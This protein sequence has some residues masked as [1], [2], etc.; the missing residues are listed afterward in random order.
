MTLDVI[1]PGIHVFEHVL[2]YLL[3]RAGVSAERQLAMSG[4]DMVRAVATLEPQTLLSSFLPSA[5]P[6]SASQHTVDAAF[7]LSSWFQ[8]VYH[9]TVDAEDQLIRFR[10][11]REGMMALPTPT[12]TAFASLLEKV[13]LRDTLVK[14]SLNGSRF[15]LRHH[16]RFCLLIYFFLFW[17]CQTQAAPTLLDTF[18]TFLKVDRTEY[19]RMLMDPALADAE[20]YAK[21]CDILL[22]ALVGLVVVQCGRWTKARYSH[23]DENFAL[24]ANRLQKLCPINFEVLRKE[25]PHEKE[26]G[27]Q[28]VIN[29][30]A[31]DAVC[32]A[33]ARS[34]DHRVLSWDGPGLAGAMKRFVPP[35]GRQIIPARDPKQ[36]L[37]DRS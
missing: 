8:K 23:D 11:A 17:C 12:A 5:V 27:L 20:I 18:N 6:A 9:F 4:E 29:Q 32:H 7:A 26:K 13:R 31:A 21:Q 19:K 35:G 30:E 37:K 36:C 1:V 16:A 24:A 28:C 25:V 10:G 34:Q 3:T 15:L 14:P 33:L 22:W 2:S